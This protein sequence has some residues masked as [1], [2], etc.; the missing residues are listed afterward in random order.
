MLNSHVKVKLHKIL[1]V[2]NKKWIDVN[3]CHPR[4]IAGITKRK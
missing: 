3:I 1:K 2:Y 4:D